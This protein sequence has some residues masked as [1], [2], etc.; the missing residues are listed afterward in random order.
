M[1]KLILGAIVAA[2][3]FFTGCE[4]EHEVTSCDLRGAVLGIDVHMCVES[5]DD[6][7]IK[8]ACSSKNT[9]FDMSTS[10]VETAIGSGCAGDASKVCHSTQNGIDFTMYAYGPLFKNADC[11]KYQNFA[12]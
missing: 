8:A 4:E 12:H 9:G 2:A 10:D 1:K 3:A 6:S 5:E 11:S 7:Y